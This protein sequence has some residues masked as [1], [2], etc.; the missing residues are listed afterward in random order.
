MARATLLPALVVSAAPGEAAAKIRMRM[1]PQS[2]PARAA[3]PAPSP[4]SAAPRRALCPFP[5]PRRPPRP[6]PALPRAALPAPSLPRA[7][8]HSRKARTRVQGSLFPQSPAGAEAPAPSRTQ[9]LAWLAM[10]W[11]LRPRG[12][13]AAAVAAAWNLWVPPRLPCRPRWRGTAGNLLVRSVTGASNQPQNSSNGS[14]R[15]TVLLPQTSFPM[16][17][18]GRQQPDTELEI[19]QVRAG[20][21]SA[22]AASGASGGV[23]GPPWSHAWATH[24]PGRA[25]QGRPGRRLQALLGQRCCDQ[26]SGN[27]A[28]PTGCTG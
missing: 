11:G 21:L 27:H 26:T 18:L 3:L 15:D 14:Y 25:E 16:K 12:P 6:F 23:T 22:R 5:A 17:L 8:A 13:G 24:I 7:R 19:Q 1:G 28:L 10:R 9:G 4:R 2:S 20:L